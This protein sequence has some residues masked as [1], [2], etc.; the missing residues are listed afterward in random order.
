VFGS[1][2][3]YHVA[4]ASDLFPGAVVP[5]VAPDGSVSEVGVVGIT[6]LD[7]EHEL[8]DLSVPALGN[9]VANGIV[10][11]NSIYGWRGAVPE[12]IKDFADEFGAKV[13]PLTA[14][15]RSTGRI[16]A[17]SRRVIEQYPSPIRA[18]GLH[19]VRADGHDPQIV[20][21]LNNDQEAEKVAQ[22]A[23]DLM[24][25]GVPPTEI[26]VLIR[27]N[28]QSQPLE[29]AFAFKKIPYT[30][31]GA[32]SFF[33]RAEVRDALSFLRV[34]ANPFEVPAFRRSAQCME[35]LGNESVKAVINEAATSKVS[36]L[37][38]LAAVRSRLRSE[39][40]S[41]AFL[42]YEDIMSDLSSFS[43]AEAVKRVTEA[44]LATKYASDDKEQYRLDNL[45]R[46]Y[47][48]AGRFGDL[49]D[50]LTMVTLATASDEEHK[51]VCVATCHAV[52]GLEF[53]AVWIAGVEDGLFPHAR[54]DNVAEECRLLYVACTRAKDLLVLSWCQVRK[55]WNDIIK[56]APS[57]F[58][59]AL[60]GGHKVDD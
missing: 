33:D 16:V 34:A 43:P 26:A 41:D 17:L 42:A 19:S 37:E 6:P 28:A 40:R 56:C 9:F 60:T 21:C 45:D 3:W 7:G 55:R 46:L 20:E 10:V 53:R 38:S 23:Q 54:A 59:G 12:N 47:Q 1:G 49:R 24:A 58:L 18:E 39:A 35:G 29:A 31:V 48:L 27:T 4:T 11:H 2:Q 8:I 36:L 25:Q 57:Q 14:N 51:G 52:K 15:H 44:V 30:V 22:W 5:S 50:F 13:Y 32:L